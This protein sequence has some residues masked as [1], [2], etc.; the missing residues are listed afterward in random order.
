[1]LAFSMSASHSALV[2]CSSPTSIRARSTI[3]VSHKNGKA[4]CTPLTRR[5][6]IQGF[7]P[8]DF[9]P[10]GLLLNFQ[11]RLEIELFDIRLKP[12]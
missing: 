10:T 5:V 7:Y 3:H 4:E 12:F 8:A 6:Q 1:M 11:S 9:K 2:V